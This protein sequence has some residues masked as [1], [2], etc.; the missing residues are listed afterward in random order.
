MIAY[1]KLLMIVAAAV[2]LPVTGAQSATPLPQYSHDKT[3][4]VGTCASSMCHG[5]VETW[6]DSNVLQNEY[7]TWSRSDKHA[8]AYPCS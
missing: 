7:V 6:K 1:R 3:L 4:G 8:R 5:A 2:L